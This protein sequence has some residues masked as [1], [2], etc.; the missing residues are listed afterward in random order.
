MA[1]LGQVRP[2]LLLENGLKGQFTFQAADG[3]REEGPLL[4]VSEVNAKGNPTRFDGE[5]SYILPSDSLQLSQ[6]RALVQQVPAKIPLHLRNG[7]FKLRAWE[8]EAEALFARPGHK[9]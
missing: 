7:V 6:L 3:I 1:N 2:R 4:S 8:P 5:R 9:A